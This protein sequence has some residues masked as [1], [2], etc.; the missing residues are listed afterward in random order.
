MKRKHVMTIAVLLGA[1]LA[2]GCGGGEDNG[3]QAQAAAEGGWSD[4]VELSLTEATPLASLTASPADYLGNT[5]RLEGEVVAVCQGSGCWIELSDAEG[6][7]FYVRSMD[8]SILF[9]KD[10]TGRTAQVQ[11]T[12][13]AMEPAGH[14]HGEEEI[15][16]DHYCPEPTYLLSVE[17]ARLL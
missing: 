11:G 13:M 17:G 5:L 7:T 1:L 6:N 12:V 2:A 8:E 16:G 4:G 3:E 9:P 15:E 10:C 14:E